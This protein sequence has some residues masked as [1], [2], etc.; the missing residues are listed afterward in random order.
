MK[1]ETL[2]PK[3]TIKITYKNAEK[4]NLRLCIECNFGGSSWSQMCL[5]I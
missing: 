4:D 2:G 1:V 3:A 5:D